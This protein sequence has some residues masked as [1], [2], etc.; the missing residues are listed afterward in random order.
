MSDDQDKCEWV[1]VSS[2]TGLP[3]LS[4][5]KAIKRLCV[6]VCVCVLYHKLN[7]QRPMIYR[8]SVVPLCSGL[9][10]A[11]GGTSSGKKSET[12]KYERL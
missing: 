4:L 11:T 3:G 2:G 10:M 7:E 1:S 12:L 6:C 8:Q 5:T 9:I